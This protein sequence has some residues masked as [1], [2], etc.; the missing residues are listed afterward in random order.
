MN[1]YKHQITEV[2]AVKSS[3]K[4]PGITIMDGPFCTIMPQIGKKNSYLLYDV[5]NSIRK[6]SDQP[7]SIAIKN[8]N[9]KLMKKKLVS[10]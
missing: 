6:V 9:F 2:V 8:S 3:L 7:K 5:I 10:T 4:F 1:K